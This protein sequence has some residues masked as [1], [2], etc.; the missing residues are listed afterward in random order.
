MKSRSWEWIPLQAVL[1]IHD[2]Q[3]AEHGGIRGVRELTVIDSALARPRNLLAYGQPDAAALA[4]S[5][6]FGLCGNHG[7]FDGNKRT[8]YV[9]AET[10]LALNGYAIDA[11]DEAVVHTVFAVAAGAMPE[12]QLAEWFRAFIR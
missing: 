9:V 4:A 10:F 2:A 1:A 7:F 11:T 3:I 12:A 6:L 5:Y 8:A